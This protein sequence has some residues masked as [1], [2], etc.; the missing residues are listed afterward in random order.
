[1]LYAVPCRIEGRQKKL[2]GKG[3]FSARKKKYV[4]DLLYAPPPYFL[5]RFLAFRSK[6]DFKTQ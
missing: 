3:N 5:P 4:R 6:G 1:M 2:E